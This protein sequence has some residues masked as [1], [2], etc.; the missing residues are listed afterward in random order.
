MQRNDD[1]V[2]LRLA[3]AVSV[4]F[5]GT[6]LNGCASMQSSGGTGSKVLMC[7]GIGAVIGGM[8]GAIEGGR[9]DA[10]KGA[11]IGAVAGALGCWIYYKNQEL[12]G[13]QETKQETAYDPSQGDLVQVKDYKLDPAVVKTG[14]EVKLNATYVVMAPEGGK[15]IQVTETRIFKKFDPKTQAY[16]E[17]GR[18]VD[19]VT[20]KPGTR[21]SDGAFRITE[22]ITPG[23]YVIAFEVKNGE[24]TDFKEQKITVT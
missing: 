2:R 20:V 14:T 4:A 13:Y 11:G 9:S 16:E 24:K 10:A 1:R 6:Q 7:A 3:L 21:S 17:L 18:A 19:K 15:D 23:E 22:D 5:L 12:K 8:I